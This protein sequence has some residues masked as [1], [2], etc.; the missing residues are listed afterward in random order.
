MKRKQRLA[1][2]GDE[3]HGENEEGEY[4]HDA[5]VADEMDAQG[6]EVQSA[7]PCAIL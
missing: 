7:A 3:N 6:E 5:E 4:G 2:D 1:T